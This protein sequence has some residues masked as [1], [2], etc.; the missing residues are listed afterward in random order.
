MHKATLSTALAKHGSKRHVLMDAVLA[1]RR[2]IASENAS[3]VVSILRSA[4]CHG[5]IKEIKLQIQKLMGKAI[6]RSYER[7]LDQDAIDKRRLLAQECADEAVI[8]IVRLFPWFSPPWLTLH[9]LVIVYAFRA[10]NQA[11]RKR[12][13]SGA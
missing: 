4:G 11:H 13:A 6:E 9:H 1:R 2:S 7:G 5:P 10:I 12:V 3:E 8:H